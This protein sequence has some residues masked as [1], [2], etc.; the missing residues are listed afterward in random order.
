MLPGIELY[1][2]RLILYGCGDFI[3]DYEGIT[4]Y[5]RYRDDLALMY[6]VE[7]NPSNGEVASVRLTPMQVR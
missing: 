4:G 2:K 3:N 6:F 7:V 1:H 5:E